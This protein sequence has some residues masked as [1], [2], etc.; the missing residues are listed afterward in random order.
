MKF[1][2]YGLGFVVFLILTQDI[3][4]FPGAF[5]SKIKRL[6]KARI[7]V[8]PMVKS[9]FVTTSD[10]KNIE[11]WKHP[12]EVNGENNKYVAIIFHGNGGSL[13]NFLFIQMYLADLGIKSYNFDYR[14]YGRSSGWPSEK[15]I[16]KDSDAVWDYVQSEEVVSSENII[17]IGISVG[18]APAARIASIHKPKLLLLASAFKDLRSAVRSQKIVGL[19]APFVRHKFP[20][21]DFVSQL[22]KTDLLIAHSLKDSIVPHQHSEMIEGSYSGSGR[23]LRLTTDDTGHNMA[24]YLSLIHI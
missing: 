13:Q 1:T 24:F 14:G 10:G 16:F 4:I 17:I 9:S 6:F 19:L 12:S 5:F 20:T 18:S 15:G 21:I 2:L 22:E 3:H 23:V 7:I 8:P 11:V